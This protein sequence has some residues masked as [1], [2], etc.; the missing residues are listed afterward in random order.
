M[1]N[2]Y[3]IVI[4]FIVVLIYFVYSFNYALQHST[5]LN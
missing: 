4:C 1:K 2:N 3:G 5:I